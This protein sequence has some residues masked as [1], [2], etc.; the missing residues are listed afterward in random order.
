MSWLQTAKDLVPC[1]R[2]LVLP[3]RFKQA[4]LS[5]LPEGTLKDTAQDYLKQFLVK[6]EQGIAPL[7][8][9]RARTWKTY[10]ASVIANAVRYEAGLEVGFVECPVEL[11]ALERVRFTTG[12]DQR[13]AEY[14]SVPFLVLDD[15]AE[16]RQGTYGE[17]VLLEIVSARHARM[18]PTLFTGNIQLATGS[19]QFAPLVARFGPMFARRVADGSEGFRVAIY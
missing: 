9:G 16:V 4:K 2:P 14:Q 17:Q 10:A 8:I 15:F 18:K 5:D 6:A 7:F 11:N 12:T 13:I 19:N 3:E 1:P